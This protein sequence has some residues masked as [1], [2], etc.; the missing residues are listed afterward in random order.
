MSG[1]TDL[2][3][4]LTTVRA[5][6][7]SGGDASIVP[8]CATTEGNAGTIEAIGNTPACSRYWLFPFVTD[9]FAGTVAGSRHY[10][11]GAYIVPVCAL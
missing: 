1:T 8:V 5:V 4:V 11:R 2:V 3:N 7:N 9:D 10:S 6:E